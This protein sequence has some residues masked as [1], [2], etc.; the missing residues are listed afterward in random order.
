MAH[1]KR[2]SRRS[3]FSCGFAPRELEALERRV[4]L[5]TA[6]GP[7]L[8][9]LQHL[10]FAIPMIGARA[11]VGD[12]VIFGQARDPDTNDAGF[13]EIYD[14]RTGRF[15]DANLELGAAVATVADQAV[16]AGGDEI[17]LGEGGA[18]GSD[19]AEVFD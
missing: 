15:T 9:S 1:L 2:E 5:A 7:L 11:V 16:F 4:L 18:P 3:W 8:V 12:D 10:G 13:V 14:A 6:A 17:G 19:M